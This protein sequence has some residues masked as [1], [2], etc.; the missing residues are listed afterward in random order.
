MYAYD[1]SYNLASVMKRALRA[2]RPSRVSPLP[3]PDSSR[4]VR[5]A[6]ACM[7]V[8]ACGCVCMY[9]YIYIYTHIHIYV[10][11]ERDREI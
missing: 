4:F 2:G 11:R 1:M 6:C 9:L 5:R 8:C 10:Y 3:S 7:H